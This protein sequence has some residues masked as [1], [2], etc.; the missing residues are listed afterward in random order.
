[1]KEPENRLPSRAP[2]RPI[3]SGAYPSIPGAP[4]SGEEALRQFSEIMTDRERAEI[5]TFR[6]IFYIRQGKPAPQSHMICEPE[7]FPFVLNDHIRYRYQ[8]LAE[9]GR[10]AFGTVIKCYDHKLKQLVAVKVVRELPGIVAQIKQEREVSRMLMTRNDSVAHHIVRIHDIL[11]YRSFALLVT[12]VLSVNLYD[13]MKASK[14]APMELTKLQAV[15]RQLADAIAF[16]HE[17]GLIHC[18]VKP[19]NVLWTSVRRTAV[20]LIDF[21]CCCYVGRTMFT[22][23]QSRFYR[24]PEVMLGLDYGREI[25]VWSFA[26]VACE[27]LTGKVL[28]PGRNECE[29][30]ALF[31]S[32]LGLPPSHMLQKASRRDRFFDKSG[33]PLA[34][35][36]LNVSCTPC[37][38]PLKS[39]VPCDDPLFMS[40]IQQCLV[41]D[42]S[43]RLKASQVLKHPWMS[44]FCG[45]R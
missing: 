42:P 43:K 19:E 17:L 3:T 30:M 12:E 27:L 22:Y 1:M 35:P 5:R 36:S 10:G 44:S 8:Q 14:F 23:I 20:K 11:N 18:D 24:A 2:A 32:S 34:V 13:A 16:V 45:Y 15:L 37:S 39:L 29:Q 6:E 38:R 4:I 31:I 9:L 28:F 21:G 26:C 7:F 41:W 25:D 33:R 40:L